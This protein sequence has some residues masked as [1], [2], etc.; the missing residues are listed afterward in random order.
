MENGI[1]QSD[2]LSMASS[3]ESRL[4]LVDYKLIETVVGLHK[5][6]P[7]SAD[8]APKRWFREAASGL[9]PDFVLNRRKRGFS[10]PWRQWGHAIAAAH[11]DELIDGYLVQNGVVRP[12]V[13]RKQRQELIP[14]LSGPR[15]LASLSLG[16]ENWCRQMSAGS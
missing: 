11:G 8:A 15:P 10:P 16:L 13:A 9:V 7:V 4:P 2:R 3:I 5:T 6:Y 1:A 14:R 12:E